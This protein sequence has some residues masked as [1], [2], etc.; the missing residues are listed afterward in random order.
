MSCLFNGGVRMFYT[1]PSDNRT[2]CFEPVPL[3]GESKEFLKT[4]AGDE[5]AIVHRLTFNGTL[6]P[7]M[8]ALS[9]VPDGATC[10]SLLD[11]KRDQ[12][13]SALSED[14]GDL[15]VVDQSGY[16]IV[17]AKPIVVSL[18]FDEGVLVQQSPY[19]VVFEYE[20]PLGSGYIRE[21]TENWSF[22]QAED[23]TIEVNHTISAVGF[24][25]PDIGKSA[26]DNAK[27]FVLPRLGMDK[28][29][30]AVMRTPFVSALIDI[31]SLGV[32]NRR[33]SE[34]VGTT[35]G[36]YE[37]QESF[38]LSSGNFQ[39]DRTI[40]QSFEL[41]ENGNLVQSITINGT[42]QG[43]GADTFERF[44]NAV[45]GF[46][47]FVVPQIGFNATSGIS[48]K[49][50]SD[51]RIA[52]TVN[53]SVSLLPSGSDDQLTGRSIQ[54]TFERQDDGSVVQNVTTSCQV[55][56]GSALDIQSAIDFCFA[57]NFPIDSAEPIFSASL[58]GNLVSVNTQRNELEK[59]FSLTRSYTDQ[60]TPLYREE[61]SVDVQQTV[62]SSVTQVS[63]N[64]TVQGLGVESTT[65]GISRFLSASGA[66][67]STIEKLIPGRVSAVIPTGACIS[68]DPTSKTL[69]YNPLGGALTYAQTFQSRFKTSNVNIL[70][71][72]VELNFQRQAD[73]IAQIPIPG[74][75]DG[76]ILQDQ[77]TKTGLQKTMSVSYTMR[78]QSD[79][80]TNSVIPSN[81][82][83]NIALAESDILVNNTPSMN[84]RGEKP[85]SSKVFKTEDTVS[86]NRNT[87]EFSRNVTWQY[88]P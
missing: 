10:I 14:R 74:K 85:E 63:I 4:A 27:D 6:L 36:S 40:E 24:P 34:S 3:L 61:Y 11:R 30:S 55:R 76:P 86:F 44:S 12:M 25:K 26:V 15:L 69:G 70:T 49:T 75:Q 5:L 67:F 71:E 2:Y 60:T 79:G 31:D 46:N 82:A 62:D 32:Y 77:E 59:S 88:L 35:D 80:C 17:S 22:N 21:Y 33:F 20:E 52:G 53:Y 29:Q 56:Q 47:A 16:P 18:D 1:R 7:T 78:R 43:R 68:T 66:Y 87:Y 23:D 57:N 72:Q 41:D 28:T 48:A 73:V 65:K 37:V 38:L 45:A 84:A 58:S 42:V 13:C 83:L 54:R 9:G 81:Q 51:N 19:T 39:D 50:R 64:G 8:P